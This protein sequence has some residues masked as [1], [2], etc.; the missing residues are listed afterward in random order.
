[1][2]NKVEDDELKLLS[3]IFYDIYQQHTGKVHPGQLRK[4]WAAEKAEKLKNQ[5][6]RS[7]KELNIK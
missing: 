1:M 4:I 7:N 5:N 6:G 3:E 2:E